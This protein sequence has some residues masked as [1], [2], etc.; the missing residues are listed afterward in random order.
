MSFMQD[1]ARW[2]GGRFYQSNNPSQVPDLFLKESIASLRPWF[3]QT[4]FFP[5][6]AAA[7]DLLQ[8]VPTDSF[9]QLGGYVVTT[10]KPSAEQYLTSTKQDPVLAAWSYGLGR[11]VAWTSDSNGQWTGGFLRSPVSQ[12]LFARMVAWTLPGGTQ[13]LKIDAQPSGDGLQVDVTGSDV[14]GAT[15]S[16]GV[17]AP[18][19]SSR[20]QDL[21]AVAP[22]HWQGRI[23]GTTVGTYLLHGVLQ[24]NGQV[25]DQADRA[26]SVPYS[27][28]YLELGRDDGL[29]RQ[30]AH[31]GSG[32]VLARAPAAWL[33]RPLPVP[34]SSDIFW[35]LLLLAALMWPLDIAVR[36]ITLSP[37]Q[38]VENA[39]GLVT[40]RRARDLEVAVPAE[41]SRLR[42]RVATTRRR[43]PV[44]PAPPVVVPAEE[45]RAP[46][47]TRERS[48]QAAAAAAER[49]KEEAA[50]SARLLEARRKRRGQ[51]G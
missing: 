45:A 16:V 44:G 50:L 48:R 7:G 18:D 5:K 10:A 4:P 23:S 15:V 13:Q 3:E 28:E 37:R 47:S 22:G 1:I 35:P 43:R 6:I 19:L 14:A 40:E 38:L 33:Q 8:G 32:V 11:S 36:R 42:E 39:I 17:Q 31:E 12:A 20:T 21:V 26:V 24:K 30:V 27:P 34:I 46:E 9:P 29:L 25:V 41:L 51:G 49:Q 2:G